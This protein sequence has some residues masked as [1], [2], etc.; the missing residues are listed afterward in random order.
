[1][2]VGFSLIS[3]RAQHRQA[4]VQS[5]VARLLELSVICHHC[6]VAHT[7]CVW[8][9]EARWPSHVK[10]EQRWGDACCCCNDVLVWWEKIMQ[11]YLEYLEILIYFERLKKHQNIFKLQESG[12]CSDV[13]PHMCMFFA[14]HLVSCGFCISKGCFCSIWIKRWNFEIWV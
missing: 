2:E 14:H 10:R 5:G 9:C 3:Q 1:M 6:L 12:V 4:Y 8:C 13:N 7:S 11:G